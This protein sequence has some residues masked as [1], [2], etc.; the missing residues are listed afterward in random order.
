[1]HTGNRSLKQEVGRRWAN[2]CQYKGE[3]KL[4]DYMDEWDESKLMRGFL[5]LSDQS[6]GLQSSKEEEIT[7]D[8]KAEEFPVAIYTYLYYKNLS[9]VQI[10]T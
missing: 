9:H 1:M 5:E 8:I 4:R 10:A 3:L 6:R 7:W 2:A